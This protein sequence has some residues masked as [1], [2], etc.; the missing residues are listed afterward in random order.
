VVD[1]EMRGPSL[2]RF[3]AAGELVATLRPRLHP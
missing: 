3:V 2:D 1:D